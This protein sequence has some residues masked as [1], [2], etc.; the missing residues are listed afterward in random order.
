MKKGKLIIVS[1]PSGSGKS[2]IVNWLM[3][4]HPE[5]KL[6]FSVSCT[7]RPPRGEEQNGVEYFFLSPEE[8]RQKIDNDEF[9]NVDYVAH[10]LKPIYPDP[11]KS[12]KENAREMAEK[13]Y[14][15]KV[16]AYE[17]AYGKKLTYDLHLDD[18]AGWRGN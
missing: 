18:I 6:A 4:E 10:V 8:F 3:N 5:L 14:K 9:Y 12:V 13:D 11:K 7:S 1:A 2:T 17:K 16:A 15:Q